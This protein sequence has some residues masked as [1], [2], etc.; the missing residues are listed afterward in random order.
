MLDKALKD[1]RI[2]VFYQ[3]IYSTEKKKFTT[4]EA[5]VRIRDKEGKLIPPGVFIPV[6]EKTGKIIELGNEVFRQVCQ[7]IRDE[8]LS[9]Y[10]IEYVEVNLSV[11]QC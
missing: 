6:A 2:E 4:A 9:Q 1:G 3:P 10:G 11:A 8:K 5:L 7:L